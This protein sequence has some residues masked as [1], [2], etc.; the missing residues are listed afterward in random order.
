MSTFDLCACGNS[1]GV[2]CS[3]DKPYRCSHCVGEERFA[4]WKKELDVEMAQE[5]LHKARAA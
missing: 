1:L 5:R 4:A 2:A 3:L